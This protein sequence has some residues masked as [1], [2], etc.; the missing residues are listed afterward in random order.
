MKSH[1]EDEST[2]STPLLDSHKDTLDCDD[3]SDPP[4][5]LSNIDVIL[6]Q[7][8]IGLFHYLITLS[9]GFC[10]GTGAVF[11]NVISFLI[12]TACDLDI[13]RENR[14]W[15]SLSVVCGLI[16]GSLTLGKLGD[17]IGR[18]RVL[19]LSST[20]ILFSNLAS[21]FAVNYNMIVILGPLSGISLGGIFSNSHIYLIEFFPRSYRGIS[22]AAMTAFVIFG[23]IYSCLIAMATLSHPFYI[24]IGSIY[25][26]HWRLYI[27]V[28]SLPTLI[29]LLSLFCLPDSIRYILKAKQ[30]IQALQ[31]I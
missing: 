5:N 19:I 11:F 26:S 29:S 21:A 17:T 30:P 20:L 13:T 1:P 18:R 15:L 28:A 22:V 14:G 10:Y 8:E 31:V 23:G 16:V 2:A 24:P 25:F 12:V 3:R 4:Q 9:S 7:I 6:D 27:L